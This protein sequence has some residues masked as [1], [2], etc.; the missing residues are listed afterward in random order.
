[1]PGRITT[2]KIMNESL[3]LNRLNQRNENETQKFNLHEQIGMGEK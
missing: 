2:W 3:L 1:M